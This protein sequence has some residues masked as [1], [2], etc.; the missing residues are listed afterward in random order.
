MAAVAVLQR[1]RIINGLQAGKQLKTLAAEL[2]VTP[3]AISQVLS[4]DPEYRSAM[5]TGL[6]V[7]LETREQELETCT[8]PLNLAR[9]RELLSHARWRAERECPQRWGNRTQID[10]TVDVG[11]ALAELSER[12]RVAQ[13]Q[14]VTHQGGASADNRSY[15]KCENETV[16][17]QDELVLSDPSAGDAT[18]HGAE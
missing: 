14:Q 17:E 16:I 4:K 7:Q 1:E 11:H 2:R 8:D 9:A 10:V 13:A 5:E 6:A 12:L 15:V 3:G 18:G